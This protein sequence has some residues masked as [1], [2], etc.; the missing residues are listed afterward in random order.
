MKIEKFQNLIQQLPYEQQSFDVN[1]KTWEKFNQTKYINRIF[2]NKQ[3]ININRFDLI[4]SNGNIADFILKTLMW[5]YPTGGRG[6]NITNLLEEENFNRLEKILETYKNQEIT[7]SQLKK[8]IK[9]INGLALSTITKFTHF[10]DTTIEGKRAVILD[11]QIIKAIN[12]GRFEEFNSL[13]GISYQN[14]PNRYLNYLKIVNELSEKL[15]V[16]PDQIEMFLFTF[17]RLLSEPQKDKFK[18]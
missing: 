12:T 3:T 11:F 5:A 1:R 14:A 7:I 4:N 10:L 9:S 13:K 15:K 8:D 17:G 6:N 2:E 18:Y 16:E